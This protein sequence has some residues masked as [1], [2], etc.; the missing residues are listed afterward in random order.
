MKMVKKNLTTERSAKT[1]SSTSTSILGSNNDKHLCCSPGKDFTEQERKE[2]LENY[3]PSGDF[4]KDFSDLCTL[5]GIPSLYVAARPKRPGTPILSPPSTS[6]SKGKEDKRN[7]PSQPQEAAKPAD[8]E[9]A[10]PTTYTMCDNL[11]DYLKP[12][13]EVETEEDGHKSYVK[14]LY[15]RGWRIDKRVIEVLSIT[16]PELDRLAVID[17]WNA[18]LDDETLLALSHCLALS[19]S[20]KT[21]RLDGNNNLVEMKFDVFM[22][23]KS[24]IQNI[25]L[26][27]CDLD[28][29]AA[30]LLGQSLRDNKNLLTLNLCF[31]K[32]TDVGAAYLAEGLKINRSLLSLN[33]GSNGIGDEGAKK[34]ASALSTFALNHEQIVA[35]RMLKSIRSNEE[36][37]G[38][39]SNPFLQDRP[40][41]AS[42]SFSKEDKKH[43]DKSNSKK[44]ESSNNK[45]KDPNTIKRGPSS[46][47]TNK[48][49][50]GQK[51]KASARQDRNKTPQ[52][53]AEGL[54]E[55]KNP[56][57]EKVIEENG[58]LWIPG[59]RSLINLNL[60]RNH[61]GEVGLNML[62][63]AV[64]Y[65]IDLAS[66]ANRVV[67]VGLMRLSL[68]KN[69]FRSDNPTYQHLMVVMAT[70]DPMYKPPTPSPV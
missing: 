16:M 52:P 64:K 21:I 32:I 69:I 4:E 46:M 38:A 57:L 13:V 14:E 62:Y 23:E 28:D 54:Y 39:P 5:I 36:L 18:G 61:I 9:D 56:L 3:K 50:K 42:R 53:E 22:T 70:R 29:R 35:R 12:R 68:Q 49:Q 44:K 59:N 48:G 45:L 19:T 7:I 10:P 27:N 43:K 40:A 51:H 63:K 33:L 55:F 30:S 66:E 41:T 47:D 24:C 37:L 6:M 15:V 26:K 34:L 8:S 2:Q 31:N 11:Y 60:A 67:G 1:I 65:Q 25:S 20:L 17:L 58:E